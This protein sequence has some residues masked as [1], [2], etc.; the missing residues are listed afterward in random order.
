MNMRIQNKV[1]ELLTPAH[2][3]N[4]FEV[5]KKRNDLEMISFDSDGNL[6][7]NTPLGWKGI[8]RFEARKRLRQTQNENFSKS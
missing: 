4:D 3:F 2:D 6:N 7:S 8:E 5:G 1:V